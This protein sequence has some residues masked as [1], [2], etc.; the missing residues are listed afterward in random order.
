MWFATEARVPRPRARGRGALDATVSPPPPPRTRFLARSASEAAGA[1]RK[2][3]AVIHADGHGR[4]S[5]SWATSACGP[6]RRHRRAGVCVAGSGAARV[7]GGLATVISSHDR[8]PNGGAPPTGPPALDADR[9]QGTQ[10][11]RDAVILPLELLLRSGRWCVRV[12]TCVIARRGNARASRTLSCAFSSKAWSRSARSAIGSLPSLRISSARAR[13]RSHGGT[14][15]SRRGVIPVCTSQ[16]LQPRESRAL[17]LVDGASHRVGGIGRA[18][19]RAALE[20][21][22]ATEQ[23]LER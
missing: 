15:F 13:H 7:V 9:I 20:A 12:S 5:A 17:L 3:A 23:R 6:R 10:Q 8:A 16:L 2:R 19:L 11:V 4:G 22:D 18:G 21:L 1:G 14:L